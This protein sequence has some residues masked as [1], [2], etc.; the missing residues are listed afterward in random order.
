MSCGGYEMARNV[1]PWNISWIYVYYVLGS[2][3]DP[4]LS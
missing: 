3:G 4:A 2:I 1:G